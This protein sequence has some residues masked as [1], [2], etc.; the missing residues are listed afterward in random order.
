VQ[1]WIARPLAFQVG[2]G[3]GDLEGI[4]DVAASTRFMSVINATVGKPARLA[5][6]TSFAPGRLPSLGVAEGAGA[7]FDVHDQ[8]SRPAATFL[9]RIEL[10]ISGID[11]TLR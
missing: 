11:S 6:A 2:D 3:L 10:T 7:A 9:L 5:T 8:P 4:A 1:P